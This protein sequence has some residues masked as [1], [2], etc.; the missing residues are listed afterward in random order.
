V[1]SVVASLS[2]V[3]SESAAVVLSAICRFQQHETWLKRNI[4]EISKDKKTARNLKERKFLI[5]ISK[6]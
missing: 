2:A 6:S 3:S 5:F 4:N 1:F